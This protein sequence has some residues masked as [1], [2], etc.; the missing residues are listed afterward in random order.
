MLGNDTELKVDLS[1][2]GEEFIAPMRE[3]CLVFSCPLLVLDNIGSVLR[4]QGRI[5][6]TIE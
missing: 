1:S 4:L 6:T 3:F 2:S 5:L